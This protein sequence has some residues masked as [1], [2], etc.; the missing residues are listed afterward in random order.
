MTDS[1]RTAPCPSS[2]N[3]G[4]TRRAPLKDVNVALIFLVSIVLIASGRANGQ[5]FTLLA[6][7]GGLTA[8]STSNNTDYN[9]LGNMNALGIGTAPTGLTAVTTSTGTLYYTPYGIQITGIPTGRN[10]YNVGVTAYVSTN[11]THPAASYVQHS[12]SCTATP[13][14]TATQFSTMSTSSAAPTWVV[15][16]PGVSNTTVLGALAIFLPD[17]DGATAYTGTDQVYVS[18]NLVNLSTNKVITG[19]T[20]VVV[21]QNENLQ[22]AVQLTLTQASGGVTITAAS[23]YSMA[24]GNVNGLGINPTSPLTAATVANGAV[25]STPYVLNPV[26]TDFTSTTGTLS[27][28]VSTNFAHPTALTLQSAN[29]A[30]GP[31]TSISTTAASPTLLTASATDRSQVTEYLGLLVLNA[32]TFTG[33]DSATLTLTLTVP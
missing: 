24:F 28:Y 21:L 2:I 4:R 31:Y 9:T 32:A 17:N 18:F 11:F 3:R 23:D 8:T 14:C 26:F 16:S 15:P 1:E 25:Y 20:Q 33:T 22:D 12:E 10:G 6:E 19:I 7:P 29:V 13:G 27:V 30:A 5:A